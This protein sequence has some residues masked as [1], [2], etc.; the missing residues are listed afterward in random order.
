MANVAQPC[1][2]GNPDYIVAMTNYALMVAGLAGLLMVAGC[3]SSSGSREFVPGKG[4]KPL[5]SEMPRVNEAERPASL[6]ARLPK[7]GTDAGNE[8]A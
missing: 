8:G 5:R 6:E 2:A 3:K 7:A 1:R 4:W